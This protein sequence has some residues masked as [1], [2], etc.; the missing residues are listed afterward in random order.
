MDLKQHGK[1]FISLPTEDPDRELCRNGR[2]VSSTDQHQQHNKNT[3]NGLMRKGSGG[4]KTAAIWNEPV[5][6]KVRLFC[7]L[8]NF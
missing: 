8:F 7:R 2:I 6:I 1:E 3:V 5:Q 4:G